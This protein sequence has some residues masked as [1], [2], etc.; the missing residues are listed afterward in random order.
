MFIIPGVAFTLSGGRM[1]HGMGYYDTYLHRHFTT[2][3]SKKSTLMA[4]A[5]KEQI[6]QDDCLPLD[7]HDVKLDKI[8]TAI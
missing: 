3:P 8:M 7:E 2:Y 1:G 5:F 4:L 6:V